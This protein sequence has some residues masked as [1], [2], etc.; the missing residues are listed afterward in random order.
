MI[1]VLTGKNAEQ[2]SWLHIYLAHYVNN[3]EILLKRQ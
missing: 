1:T 3:P 2:I